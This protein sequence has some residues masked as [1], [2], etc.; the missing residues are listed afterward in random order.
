MAVAKTDAANSAVVPRRTRF[1]ITEPEKTTPGGLEEAPASVNL[2][3][4]KPR[5]VRKPPRAKKTY[6]IKRPLT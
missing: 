3:D 2:A 4:G 6:K 5:P 1:T